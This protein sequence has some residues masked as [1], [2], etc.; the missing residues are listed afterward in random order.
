VSARPL[1]PPAAVAMLCCPVCGAPL[2]ASETGLH[3]AA[4][5]AFDRARHGHVTLLPPGHRPP[6]A[7]SAEMVADRVA[8]LAAGH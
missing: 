8:F 7:D 3:C 5:H 4:G 1:L 6:S 2:A